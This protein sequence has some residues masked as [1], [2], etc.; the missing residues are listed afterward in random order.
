MAA[1]SALTWQARFQTD[2]TLWMD[3]KFVHDGIVYLRQHGVAADWSDQDLWNGIAD[4]LEQLGSLQLHLRWIPSH[5]DESL[6]ENPFEDWVHLWNGRVDALVGH[7]NLNRPA[8]FQELWMS[9]RRYH[10]EVSQRLKQL[11]I[12]FGKVAA[13]PKPTTVLPMGDVQ[14]VPDTQP[15]LQDFYTDEIETVLLSY[16]EPPGKLFTISFLTHML[17]WLISCADEN[18]DDLVCYPICYEEIGLVL[19]HQPHFGFPFWNATTGSM[20]AVPLCTRYQK[21]TLAYIVSVVRAALSFLR[22]CCDLFACV[23]FSHV[24]KVSLGIHRPCS[25]VYVRMSR[26]HVQSCSA[27]TQ[28]FTENRPIRKTCDLARPVQ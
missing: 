17:H 15:A 7:Y 21:P 11:S 12:F 4:Q 9:A 3:A 14:I 27:L 20:D 24:N 26:A 13:L 6:L 28:G 10:H 2:M 8:D 19:A 22:E 1:L 5:L 23:F 25:G 18:D 16:H